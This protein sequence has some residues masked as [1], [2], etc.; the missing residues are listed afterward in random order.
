MKRRHLFQRTPANELSNAEAARELQL[1]LISGLRLHCHGSITPRIGRLQRSVIS[2]AT[3]AGL[4]LAERESG[5]R[6]ANELCLSAAR[7]EL[8]KHKKRKPRRRQCA[9]KLLTITS[10]SLTT[11]LPRMGCDPDQFSSAMRRFHS[12]RRLRRGFRKGYGT[13]VQRRR[14]NARWD[15]AMICYRSRLI[16]YFLRQ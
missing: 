16:N 6:T 4:H 3:Y 9:C 2:H 1:R 5:C 8:P 13:F 11:L 10:S 12:L 7:G 15:V 14:N